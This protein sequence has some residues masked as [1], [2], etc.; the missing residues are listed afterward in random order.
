ML[1]YVLTC[2][3][4][5]SLISI[6]LAT[7]TKLITLLG[8]LPKALVGQDYKELA[9]RVDSME[10]LSQ[11]REKKLVAIQKLITGAQNVTPPEKVAQKPK[12]I[13]IVEEDHDHDHDHEHSDDEVALLPLIKFSAPVKGEITAGFDADHFHMGI[14]LAA[15]AQSEIRAAAEGIVIFSKFTR[16]NGYTIWILHPSG[17]KT[18][19]KHNSLL[20]A[21]VGQFVSQDEIIAVIGNTGESSTGPHLHFE[22]WRDNV[23]L[24]PA[25]FI[26]F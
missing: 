15:K 24:D 9:A 21:S 6:L 14:D 13:E 17:Y 8:P 22:L 4:I 10:Y 1:F 19:Y 16:E 18:S 2:A 23:A 26:R 7:Q 11:E 3:L 5:V 20:Y 25:K 12:E